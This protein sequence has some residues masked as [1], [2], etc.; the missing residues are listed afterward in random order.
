MWVPTAHLDADT[1]RAATGVPADLEFATKPRLATDL[2]TETLDA[3][4]PVR[5]CTADASTTGTGD[6]A[7]CQTRGIGCR[8]Q[9][10]VL[11]P[12]HSAQL[13][14]EDEGPRRNG[15]RDPDHRHRLAGQVLRGGLQRRPLVR[16][17]VNRRRRPRHYLLVRRSLAEPQ[18]PD[19]LYSAEYPNTSRRP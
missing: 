3:G 14:D 19:L 6:Y 1:R 16:V 5:W 10:A 13:E 7:A 8:P 17:G 18:R 4:V 9:R 2:L 15:G 12:D 11:V